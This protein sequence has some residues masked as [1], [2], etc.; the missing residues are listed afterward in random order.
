MAIERSQYLA[1]GGHEAVR[2]SIVE[3]LSLARRADGCGLPV[4]AWM[5]D[6]IEYRMYP[7]GVTSL[8]EGWTKNLSAGASS[9]PLPRAVA[10]GLWITATLAI[11]PV[12]GSGAGLILAAALL[13]QA[14]VFFR[15]VGSFGAIDALLLP[16]ATA[17]FVA[18][19]VRSTVRRVARR[20]VRWRDR[21]VPERAS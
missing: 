19:F 11:V 4:E 16:L 13:L 10:V 3:D 15:R 8:L 7:E 18:M 12:A 9:I 17:A 21:I 14:G 1:I 20:P 6:G 5:G 2:S